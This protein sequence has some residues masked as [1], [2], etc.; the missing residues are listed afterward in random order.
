M[1][2][3][4]LTPAQPLQGPPSPCSSGCQ[5]LILGGLPSPFH[6]E[7]TKA[8]AVCPSHVWLWPRE[9]GWHV[10]SGP[11]GSSYVL[12]SFASCWGPIFFFSPCLALLEANNLAL[13]V[14][15]NSENSLMSFI[16]SHLWKGTCKQAEKYNLGIIYG[17]CCFSGRTLFPSP[18]ALSFVPNMDHTA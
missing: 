6:A 8:P 16:Q 13:N 2:G 15:L 5:L 1:Q 10:P 11:L 14:D 3:V 12:L 4:V 18:P 17:V 7:C 9:C